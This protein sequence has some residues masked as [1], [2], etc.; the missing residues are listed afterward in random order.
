MAPTGRLLRA[1]TSRRLAVVSKTK[2]SLT[3]KRCLNIVNKVGSTYLQGLPPKIQQI[4]R[5]L[6]QGICADTSRQAL[7]QDKAT[8]ILGKL[9]REISL[10]LDKLLS[11]AQK[12]LDNAAT[13][14]E[15]R[16][17]A[18]AD[19][20]IKLLALQQDITKQRHRLKDALAF[21]DAKKTGLTAVKASQ[22]V[23]EAEV[24][25][26]QSRKRQ[27]EQVERDCYEPLKR[28][29]ASNHEGGRQMATLRRT[30]KAYGF[31]KELLGIAPV[32]LKKQLDS[33]RTF[34]NLI[35]AQLA[36]EF[37]KH[38]SALE[39]ETK[40]CEEEA[41]KH[42]QDVE[43]AEAELE[44]AKTLHKKACQVL[45]SMAASV[46][47]AQ[48]EYAEAKASIRKLP[49]DLKRAERTA[50]RVEERLL[51]FQRG[52]RAAFEKAMGL[53]FGAVA[54][55]PASSCS[56]ASLENLDDAQHCSSTLT[57]SNASL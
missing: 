36:N 30:G 55:L 1:A 9:L 47:K 5:R 12:S 39:S 19:A 56:H 7:G 23:H 20:E 28:A 6:R 26:L 21:I 32:V 27:L 10:G 18:A 52:P 54:S 35:L 13:E 17:Q 8:A 34:D 38:S 37:T 14:R 22:Q 50:R 40:S 24:R 49:A 45:E 33:R 16:V 46:A 53:E 44:G 25:K 51:K 48:Q 31:H 15:A 57:E 2:A 4:V 3:T 42:S 29:G 11:Q 41:L 43:K